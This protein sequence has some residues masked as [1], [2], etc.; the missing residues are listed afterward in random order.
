VF[1]TAECEIII[2]GAEV[3]KAREP[4]TV[5]VYQTEVLVHMCCWACSL[6]FKVRSKC[7]TSVCTRVNS[8]IRARQNI[9]LALNDV[10]GTRKKLSM[11]QIN[12][13]NINTSSL[14]TDVSWIDVVNHT[15]ESAVLPMLA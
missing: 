1:E 8:S 7:V 2:F 14:A 13:S 10:S 15:S 11:L 5:K 3:P 9:A 6:M 12:L 4:N